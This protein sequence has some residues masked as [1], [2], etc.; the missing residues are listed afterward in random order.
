[1]SINSLYNFISPVTGRIFAN[2]DYVLVGNRDGI[3]VSSPILIDIRLDIINLRK[4]FD[5]LSTASFVIGTPNLG[6][7]N[8]QVLSNLGNGFLYNN[9]GML[10]TY[11]TIPLGNLTSLTEGKTWVGDIFGRP[12]EF[13]PEP[14]PEGPPGPRGYPGL[15]FKALMRQIFDGLPNIVPEWAKKAG[16]AAIN[17]IFEDWL[18][19]YVSIAFAGAMGVIGAAGAAG[20]AGKN[21]DK[22][23]DTG[24]KGAAGKVFKNTKIIETNLNM[25]GNRIENL[26]ASPATDFSLINAKWVEDLLNNQLVIQWQ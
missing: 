10:R 18:E 2:P 21:F 8:A 5:I 17:E 11:N 13:T 19:A 23:G 22:A 9:I 3:T 16:A 4:Q 24:R 26:A 14:G 7:P 6:L 1:M 15:S 12:Y 20:A 25:N